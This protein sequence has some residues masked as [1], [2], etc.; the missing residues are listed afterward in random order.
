MKF[1]HR[2]AYY[3]L[4]FGIGIVFLLFFLG[5]KNARC[6]YFPNS[7]V[8]NDLSSKPIIYSEKASQKLAEKWVDTID[9]KNSMKYGKVDFKNSNVEIEKGKRYLIK[10]KTTKNQQITIEMINLSDRVILKDIEKD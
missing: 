8:L 9:I 4:G 2:L 7:R 3:I 5:G 6:T 10:G 1:V